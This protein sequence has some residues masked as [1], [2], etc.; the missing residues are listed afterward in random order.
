[1]S[2]AA[3]ARG[4]AGA[5][6]G[7][8]RLRRFAQLLHQRLDGV[9]NGGRRHLP[10]RAKQL[11]RWQ[12]HV[13]QLLLRGSH[14]RVQRR[15]AST[16]SG[17]GF[18]DHGSPR[19]FL[20]AEGLHALCDAPRSL[21]TRL[22][23]PH[24]AVHVH[25]HFVGQQAARS[26]G[27]CW[28]AAVH[29]R[30]RQG[31]EVA[32]LHQHRKRCGF[33]AGHGSARR[34]ANGHRGPRLNVLPQ[35]RHERQRPGVPRQQSSD[36]RRGRLGVGAQA[37]DTKGPV[38]PRAPPCL[39][40]VRA[41]RVQQMPHAHGPQC[42]KHAQQ[43]RLPRRRGGTCTGF[44]ARFAH[45][46]GQSAKGGSQRLQAQPRNGR[47]GAGPEPRKHAAKGTRQR[48]ADKRRRQHR[49]S[50]CG[51]EAVGGR[52]GSSAPHV[53]GGLQQRLDVG[54]KRVSQAA[55]G[56]ALHH[57]GGF[58]SRVALGVRAQQ[59]LHDQQQ[60][61]ARCHTACGKLAALQQEKRVFFAHV[62]QPPEQRVDS[63]S[64]D[65]SLQAAVQTKFIRKRR[66]DGL[67]GIGVRLG[68]GAGVG[69]GVGI[70]VAVAGC[71]WWRRRRRH[72]T[73][74]QP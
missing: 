7:E 59:P 25:A 70:S 49:R 57:V 47:H 6:L 42:A 16:S 48:R 34:R 23:K 26:G 69:V 46:I 41:R 9:L 24:C 51:D 50:F 32:L 12:R 15:R 38:Q 30:A 66:L 8:G 39:L 2:F 10:T 3:A 40:M 65:A 55:N 29:Q 20:L 37:A 56:H 58:L 71:R 63:G 5:T 21:P 67:L 22:Q 31:R 35:R 36:K 68:V 73:D 4:V 62:K 1:M 17:V 44:P 18:G 19:L 54:V 53:G 74:A 72:F 52:F 43:P 11:E 45:H 28:P 64:C 27:I 13:A 14:R 33:D 60:L 61:R